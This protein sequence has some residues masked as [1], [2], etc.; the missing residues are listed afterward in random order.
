[1]RT[2]RALA[3]ATVLSSIAVPVA[4]ADGLPVLGVDVGASGV[5]APDGGS[6]YVTIPAPGGSRRAG[7][8]ILSATF[9]RGTFTVPAVAY[10][11]SASGLS[12]DRHT[13]VLI[14]PR[15]T[16]PRATTSL[17]VLH[18]PGLAYRALVKLRG[19]FSF[20][21]VS[22]NGSQL[23][24]IQYLSPA[25]PTRYAVRRFDLGTMRLV[26]AP[27]VDPR[28]AGEAMRG[29][30]LSRVESRDGGMAYTLYDGGGAHP[31]IHALDT[32]RATARCIDIT[33]L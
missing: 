28:E 1:V 15:R 7:G 30:P 12:G 9:H 16:F 22:P 2:L 29:N 17:L 6:R 19:D 32:A 13:L 8:Q 25:D 10:D 26:A 3:V 24:L 20:D 31:F 27:V 4:A 14:E 11:G 23:Y 18:A 21:A 33:G 5:A